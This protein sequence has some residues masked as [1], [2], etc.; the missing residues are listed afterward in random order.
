MKTCFFGPADLPAPLPQSKL[1][2]R[3]REEGQMRENKCEKNKK[4]VTLLLQGSSGQAR[5]GVTKRDGSF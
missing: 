3:I 5:T 2:S 4:L 1:P